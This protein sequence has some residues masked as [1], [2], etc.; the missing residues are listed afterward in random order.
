MVEEAIATTGALVSY[1]HEGTGGHTS[2]QTICG[3]CH[4]RIY[5]RNSAVPGLIVLRAGTL[6]GSDRIDPVAHIWVKRKQ[7]WLTLPTDVPTWLESPTPQEFG[8]A[9]RKREIIRLSC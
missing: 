8:D 3:V 2:T 6:D 1:E 5:N 9:L 4:T 7:P